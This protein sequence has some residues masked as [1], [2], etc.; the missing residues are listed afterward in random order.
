MTFA[1]LKARSFTTRLAA[2][3]NSGAKERPAA[4]NSSRMR[5]RSSPMATEA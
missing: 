1:S 5:S 4:F 3:S 2:A